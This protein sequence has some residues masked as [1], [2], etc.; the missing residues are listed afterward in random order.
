MFSI[1]KA[2]ENIRASRGTD[3]K[4]FKQL[5]GCSWLGSCLVVAGNIY[6]RKFRNLSQSDTKLVFYDTTRQQLGARL[7]GREALRRQPVLV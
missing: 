5:S 4:S 6:S 1:R 3:W 2:R 7:E